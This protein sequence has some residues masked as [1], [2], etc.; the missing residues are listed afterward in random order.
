MRAMM[1]TVCAPL[2]ITALIGTTAFAQTTDGANRRAQG[3]TPLAPA[4]TSKKQASDQ[5]GFAWAGYGSGH[6]SPYRAFNA[7]TPN[8]VPGAGPSSDRMTAVKDCAAQSRKYSQTTWGNM[9]LH[10]DRTCMAQ[11]GHME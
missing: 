11:R 10:Q 3:D 7:V 1:R 2:A 5:P 9:E 4:Q 6:D 8:G